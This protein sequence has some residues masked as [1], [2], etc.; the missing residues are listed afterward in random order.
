MNDD[1]AVQDICR[2]I[3]REKAIINAAN[4][5]RQATNNASVNS[6]ADSQIRDAR[7][8]IAYFEQTLNDL[9]AR[10]VGE[11]M[12]NMSVSDNGGPPPP[13]HGVPGGGRLGGGSNNFA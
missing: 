12:G 3:D 13:Q 10:K 9:Q 1:A 2:K 5:L 4:Q 6:R 11:G 7:R 8:N